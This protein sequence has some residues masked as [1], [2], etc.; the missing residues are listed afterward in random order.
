VKERKGK[1]KTRHKGVDDLQI[2]TKLLKD[3][4]K[5]HRAYN[6]EDDNSDVFNDDEDED[7]ESEDIAALLKDVVSKIP[8]SD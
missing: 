8:E 6:A 4:H 5:K 2:L 3:K 1:G 7:Y